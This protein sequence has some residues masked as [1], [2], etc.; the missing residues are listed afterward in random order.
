MEDFEDILPAE[1]EEA[2][3]AEAPQERG[4]NRTFIILVAALG[5]LLVLSI[6]AF[7]AWSVF[8]APNMRADIEERNEATFATNTAVAIAIAA[9]ET[10][11]AAPTDTPIPT[12]TPAPTDTPVPTEKPTAPPPTDTP[13]PTAT[14]LLGTPAGAEGQ[15][16]AEGAAE[17]EALPDTG[18]GVL[19][20]AVVAAVLVVL[21]VLVRRLRGTA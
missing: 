2:G 7:V 20:G 14:A 10:A 12:N 18:V 21:L 4:T 9:T 8:I 5:G 15:G 16:A 19:A 17:S 6:G 1:Q 11:A 13:E 3:E